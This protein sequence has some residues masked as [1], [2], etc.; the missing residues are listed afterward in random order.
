MG[1]AKYVKDSYTEQIQILNQ[2]SMNGYNRLFGGQL[3]EWIDVVAAIVAR[4]H[5]EKNVT[6]ASIDNLRFQGPAYANDSILLAGK[7]TYVGT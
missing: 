4:R 5:C 3:L 2:S 6:T 1:K 7:L